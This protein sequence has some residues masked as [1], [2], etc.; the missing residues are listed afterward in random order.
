LHSSGT[1]DVDSW[2][3]GFVSADGS[4]LPEREPERIL[5]LTLSRPLNISN[6]ICI[7]QSEICE[8]ATTK[9]NQSAV[10]GGYYFSLDV[11]RLAIKSWSSS[12]LEFSIG[13]P[14]FHCFIE[15]YVITRSTRTITGLSTADGK[16]DPP[17]GMSRIADMRPLKLSFVNGSD[18]ARKLQDE[19]EQPTRALT[20]HIVAAL[21]I[22]WLLFCVI[23]LVRAV[24][25]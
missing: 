25:R 1:V 12:T 24:R 22:A 20:F 11:D 2:D 13:D 5:F 21:S 10:G 9:L 7:R 4:W 15:T 23:W 18:L 16:C 8:V 17:K 3:K 19:E 6:I 14:L